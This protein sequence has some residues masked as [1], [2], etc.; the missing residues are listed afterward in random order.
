MEVESEQGPLTTNHVPGKLVRE[1]LLHNH[2]PWR[3]VTTFKRILFLEDISSFIYLFEYHHAKHGMF[4]KK[5][6]R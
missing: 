4:K 2:G 6:F 3:F 5:E 1:R